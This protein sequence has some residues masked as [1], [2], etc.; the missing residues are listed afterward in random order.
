MRFF[1]IISLLLQVIYSG[2]NPENKKKLLPEV[3][4]N[5]FNSYLKIAEGQALLKEGDLVVR[6]N[7]NPI[8]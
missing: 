2:I 3:A 7:Q 1:I 4:E 8:S 5:Y 6:L